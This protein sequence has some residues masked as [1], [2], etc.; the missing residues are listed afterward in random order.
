MEQGKSFFS[1]ERTKRT[2]GFFLFGISFPFSQKRGNE[3]CG[4]R[5]R[6]KKDNLLLREENCLHHKKMGFSPKERMLCLMGRKVL[7]KKL[8]TSMGEISDT[9]RNLEI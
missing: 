9:R 8:I 3:I 5:R 1:T 4:R 7:K 2:N 6:K